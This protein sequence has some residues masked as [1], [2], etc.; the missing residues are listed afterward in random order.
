VLLRLSYLALA[1]MVA[2]A[3]LLPMNDVDK[4]IEILA[5]RHQLAILQRQVDR[6]RLAPPERAFLAALLHA[7]TCRTR[8]RITP[9]RLPRPALR[10]LHLIISPDTVL[11]WHRDLLRRHHAKASRPK[12]PGRPPTVRSIRV[13][14]L[15]LAKEN[16]SWGYR[17]IHGELAALGIK[18]APSTVWEILKD[19]G[20]D[21]V[22]ERDR[23]TWTAFLRGQAHAIL[24]ADFFET[25]T[26]TGA[27]L[28]VF[29]VIEHTTRRVRVLGATAHPTATWTTQLA[30]NLVM[31]LQDAGATVRYQIRD[32]DN[33]YTAAFDAVFHSEGIAIVK[34]GIQVP[35]MN[36]IMERWVRTCRAELLDRTLIV[37]RSHLLHALREYETF[38]NGH[39]P[40][41]TLHAAAPLR[42]PYAPPT[43]APP[44]DRQTCPTRPPRHPTTRPTRRHPPRIP[45]RR[46]TCT[47][48]IFG[49]CSAEAAA[50]GKVDHR[51]THL[52]RT[53][54]NGG[55]LST[56]PRA[57]APAWAAPPGCRGATIFPDMR[58]CRWLVRAGSPPARPAP[59]PALPSGTRFRARQTG[60][61]GSLRV[62]A[63]FSANR[64][65]PAR[66]FTGEES[67]NGCRNG[68]PCRCFVVAEH[69]AW[70]DFEANVVSLGCAPEV[71]SRH[72]QAQ[73]GRK[74][75]APRGDVV[76]QVKGSQGSGASGFPFRVTVVRGIG[77][78]AGCKDLAA[79]G[80]DAYVG[81]P[82]VTLKLDRAPANGIELR[83][84]IVVQ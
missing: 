6:P 25:R 52:S 29:A 26:L 27:R 15:R 4:D 83:R 9:A 34:T 46:L 10:H 32:R 11:R 65:Q 78:D 80:M 79:N 45:T 56:I 53:V 68:L 39:R 8:T 12:R 76:R 73:V 59:G 3:R 21:P 81:A 72:G 62:V 61:Q 5:L 7:G 69:G 20:V 24:A 19:A 47:D 63:S 60:S 55:L 44:A 22:P 42:H 37:N 17:R 51:S 16:A 54:A 2:F 57:E 77:R 43:P 64:R 40:H 50:V 71:D 67:S 31:D 1:N 13:L 82:D 70:V 49:T 75:R 58:C 36:A 74:S 48:D 23:P 41:R 66:S 33:R 14:V 30:R 18:A 84:R 28:Y 35:R 38:Y